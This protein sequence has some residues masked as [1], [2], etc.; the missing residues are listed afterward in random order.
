MSAGLLTYKLCD[1]DFDCDSCPLDAALRG[2]LP[3]GP[4]REPL[5]TPGRDAPSFP[6]DRYYTAGHTWIQGV[7]GRGNRLLRCGIDAFSAA[8]IGRCRQVGWEVSEQTLT[9]GATMC[10]I[11]IDLGVLPLGTPIRGV[12]VA[13]NIALLST[14]DLLIT[15]PYEDGWIVEFRAKDPSEL[16]QLLTFEVARTNAQKDL[17]SFRRRVANQ[18]LSGADAV[19]PSANDGG[20]IISDLRQMLGG[21]AYL[22]LLRDLI[23]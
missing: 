20:E 3:E 8:V 1:H 7:E 2:S 12:V 14:P 16:E 17:Q 15:A 5:L 9:R 19:G 23:H 13:G 21:P 6:E 11:D 10:Q 22:E 4:R 18:L